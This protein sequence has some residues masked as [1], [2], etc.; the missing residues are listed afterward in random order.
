LILSEDGTQRFFAAL[1]LCPDSP[2]SIARAATFADYR[3]TD[4]TMLITSVIA[5]MALRAQE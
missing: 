3:L 5:Q 4:I 1:F 2:H